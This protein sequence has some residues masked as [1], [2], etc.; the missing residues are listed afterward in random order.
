MPATVYYVISDT[1]ITDKTA[2]NVKEA[3]LSDTGFISASFIT[4][5]CQNIDSTNIVTIEGLPEET[6][7]FTYL[8]AESYATDT[9]LQNEVTAFQ[10]KTKKRLDIETYQSPMKARAVLYVRYVPD[11]VGFIHPEKKLLPLIIFL[12]GNGEVAPP[13]EIKLIQ[14]GSIPKYLNDGHDI[15]FI[16]IAPEHT[17]EEWDVDFIHE[18]V[19]YS[20][21]TYAVDPNR[22][23]I[24]GMSGGGIGTLSYAMAY[25]EIPAAI[26][27]ISGEGETEQAC[28]LTDLA[29]WA[30]HNQEDP[31][32]PSA[33]SVEMINAI[34]A[35]DPGPL[36]EVNLTIFLDEGHN[37]WIRVYNPDSNMWELDPSVEPVNIYDWMLGQSK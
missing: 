17:E 15:P 30:F 6:E 7:L 33:G 12:G 11:E 29:V 9:V 18:V 35:C 22:I 4:V 2:T 1:E 31:K 28:K 25:P 23:I 20:L 21:E 16:V 19:E 5:S 36:K 37:C 26:V 27:P 3:A 8:V 32:V 34:K 14:N 24:T 13:G 10:F